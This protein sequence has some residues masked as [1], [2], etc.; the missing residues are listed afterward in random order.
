MSMIANNRQR[1]NVSFYYYYNT[2]FFPFE[3]NEE[4]TIMLIKYLNQQSEDG[5]LTGNKGE[6]YCSLTL[7]LYIYLYFLDFLFCY[8]A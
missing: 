3:E 5:I 1:A 2:F 4:M 8:D 6:H 7:I